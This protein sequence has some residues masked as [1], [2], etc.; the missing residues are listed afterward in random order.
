MVSGDSGVGKVYRRR[1]SITTHK[2]DQNFKVSDGHP[3]LNF[4]GIRTTTT[5][6]HFNGVVLIGSL[7]D[8]VL[9]AD[10]VGP[11]AAFAHQQ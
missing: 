6:A 7:V 1:T 4:W 10:V 5:L 9:S 2:V 11:C 3:N 8:V